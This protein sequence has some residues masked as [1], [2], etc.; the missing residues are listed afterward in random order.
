MP[1]AVRPLQ[2]YVIELAVARLPVALGLPAERAL[3]QEGFSPAEIIRIYLSDIE[4]FAVNP[5]VMLVVRMGMV[6]DIR[7]P[8][9]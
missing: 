9:R 8:T 6:L 5:I 4:R 2:A 1:P 3:S 7:S